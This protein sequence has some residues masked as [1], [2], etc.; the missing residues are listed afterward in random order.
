VTTPNPNRTTDTK[1]VPN[2]QLQTYFDR[3]TKHFLLRES[4]N[5]VDTEVLSPD[6]GAQFE[7]EGAHLLG[8]T[9]DPRDNALQFELEGGEHRIPSPKEVWTSEE[10][11]GFVKAIEIVRDD[12]TRE[13]TRVNRLGVAPAAPPPADQPNR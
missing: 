2:D 5:S 1:R 10:E 6:W 9:Y 3:F 12:G 7:A 8:I 13:V 11:D 4:T